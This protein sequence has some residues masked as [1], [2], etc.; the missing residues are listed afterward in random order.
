MSAGKIAANVVHGLSGIVRFRGRDARNQFWPYVAFLFVVMFFIPAPPALD[1]YRELGSADRA[2]FLARVAPTDEAHMYLN[3][4]EL[5]GMFGVF[6][7]AFLLLLMAAMVRRLHDVG[8][9]GAHALIN[10]LISLWA[11]GAALM[12][13][14]DFGQSYEMTLKAQQV[15]MWVGMLWFFH[16]GYLIIQLMRRGD[17]DFNHGGEPE[18]TKRQVQVETLR[19][20]SFGKKAGEEG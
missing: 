20:R 1:L 6:R 9:S 2:A 7:Q 17:P 11:L 19:R 10:V 15:M 5:Q 13:S 12:A 8:R 18:I 4:Y 3:L 16:F 14:W